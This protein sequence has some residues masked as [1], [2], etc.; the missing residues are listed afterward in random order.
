MITTLRVATVSLTLI[1][2]TT[3]LNLEGEEDQT[4][5]LDK[6]IPRVFKQGGFN[7]VMSNPPYG[8]EMLGRQKDYF[9]EH[10]QVF[11]GMADLYSYFIEKSL[12]LVNQDGLYGVIVANK[13][14]RANYGEPLRKFL[15]TQQLYEIIDFGD[16][17][18]FES[19]TTYPCILIIG[20]PGKEN[21]NIK[22][23]IPETLKFSSLAA[24]VNKTTLF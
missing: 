2:M 21:N 15:K 8:Q 6:H 5:Q 7:V 17:P 22:L 18:V 13:W 20:K 11:H 12:K 10:F 1:S 19:A 24:Y 4:I 14:M 9:R 23:T 3:S 16:L